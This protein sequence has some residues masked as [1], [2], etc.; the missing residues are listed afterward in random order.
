MPTGHTTPP[1]TPTV[2]AVLEPEERSRVDAAGS[3]CF[4]LV[5]RD[6]IR[7]VIRVVRERP[8][9]AVLVS[10]RRCAGEGPG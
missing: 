8:V 4:A 7:D 6:T 10:V 3:G 2:A 1:P 9:D 5:H